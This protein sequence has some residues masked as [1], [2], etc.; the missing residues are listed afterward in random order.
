MTVREFETTMSLIIK[1]NTQKKK[2]EN[3]RNKNSKKII[4][5]KKLLPCSLE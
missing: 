4:G 2:K 5:S 1:G 3:N